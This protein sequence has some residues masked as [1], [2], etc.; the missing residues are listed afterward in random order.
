MFLSLARVLCH[1][2]EL[3]SRGV[4]IDPPLLL[5]WVSRHVV[6]TVGTK[7]RC[8]SNC[9]TELAVSEKTID[10]FCPE[11]PCPALTFLCRLLFFLFQ[12]PRGRRLCPSLPETESEAGTETGGQHG[13]KVELAFHFWCSQE[14]REFLLSLSLL[15]SAFS[16][17]W[18]S[19]LFPYCCV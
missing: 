6:V 2:S 12:H 3:P 16:F 7:C 13:S 15:Y 4:S 18:S 17:T 19:C 14:F 1:P 9:A 5:F 10:I 8:L 11:N